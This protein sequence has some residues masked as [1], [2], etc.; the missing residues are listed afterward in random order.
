MLKQSLSSCNTLLQYL[1][2]LEYYE[3]YDFEKMHFYFQIYSEYF[4]I[5]KSA[6]A[7]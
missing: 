1:R 4:C 7:T 3:E 2:E 5:K 6:A